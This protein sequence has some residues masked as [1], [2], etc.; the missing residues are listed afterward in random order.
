[1]SQVDMN[2][3]VESFFSLSLSLFHVEKASLG[4]NQLNLE[5]F[6]S[7]INLFVQTVQEEMEN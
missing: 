7:I 4:I 2:E 1:M 6:F 3:F 5:F